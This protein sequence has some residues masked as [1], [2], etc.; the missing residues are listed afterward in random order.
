MPTIVNNLLKNKG[1]VASFG[2]IQFN[3]NGEADEPDEFAALE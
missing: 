2:N 1:L 3:E